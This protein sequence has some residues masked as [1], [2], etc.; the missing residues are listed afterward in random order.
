MHSETMTLATY[1]FIDSTKHSAFHFIAAHTYEYE[2]CGIL[3]MYDRVV[4]EF[5]I[6]VGFAHSNSCS[7]T[8]LFMIMGHISYDSELERLSCVRK[9]YVFCLHSQA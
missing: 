8:P 7:L 2:T 9:P 4:R 1:T 3:T 5:Y 6:N